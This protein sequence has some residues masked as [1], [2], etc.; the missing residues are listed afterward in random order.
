MTKILTIGNSFAEN[1]TR[2]LAAIRAAEPGVD[3][4]VGKANLGGCSLEKHWNLVE[5]CDLLPEVKP[6][7]FTYVGREGSEPA[8]LR[9]ALRA[10]TWDYVTFQQVSDKNWQPETYYPYLDKL[11]ALV[12][13]HVRARGGR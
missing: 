6:Y 7:N 3:L 8:T 5:Q 4:V 13:Q 1:A 12:R 10:E 2:Y 9:D 11:H